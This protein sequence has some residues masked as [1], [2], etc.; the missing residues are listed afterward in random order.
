MSLVK[1]IN[2]PSFG[3][4]RGGLVAIESN[5]SIPFDVKR[6]YYIFNTSQ[7]PR[8]FH[9]H[10]DLKQVAICLKGSC[11]FILDNGSTKEEVVLDN[12]TQGLVIEGLIWR[13]MHDFSEDCVLLV[14]ASEH[15]TEQD[16]IR[17]YDEF[18][19][20]VNQ[21][22]IHPLSDVK[23]K[24]IGQKTK[25]WQYS[26]I[27]PQAV[28]GENCNICAHTMIENDVQIGNN[29]T[30]KSGVYVWDGITLEDNVFVGPSVTFTNDKTPRSKQYPDEFLK[31]IV[32][33]GASIGGN[34]TILP[35][36]RIGRNALVGAGAVVT[37]DVPENAIVVGNPAIIKGYVK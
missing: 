27:F 13:E 2:L 10:I 1:L 29:V 31:T 32:E 6:L 17:N 25:V 14:L 4:E 5:H 28:I 9:A 36:I 18:L 24:N 33:Q 37:K 23:S 15:F 3:D 22:Y 20:V 26:V 16:Y 7:K 11:R 12:P 19:R 34:A 30:I 21:P 8:G 35:G